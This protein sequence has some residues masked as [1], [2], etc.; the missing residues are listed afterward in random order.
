MNTAVQ[1]SIYLSERDPWDRI[2]QLLHDEGVAGASAF[3]AVAGFAGRNSVHRARLVESGGEVPVL[4]IFVDL[5]EH[6][7]RVLPKVSALVPKRLIVRE[8]V[9]IEQGSLE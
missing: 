2:L 8:N 1:I 5:E 9:R 6:V 3:H 7:D 4:I